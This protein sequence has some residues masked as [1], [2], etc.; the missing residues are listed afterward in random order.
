MTDNF[1]INTPII[2]VNPN[3][4]SDIEAIALQL[5]TLTKSSDNAGIFEWMT[6]RGWTKVCDWDYT[7][8]IGWKEL[9]DLMR[10]IFRNCKVQDT[11]DNPDI[12]ARIVVWE[13]DG[14]NPSYPIETVDLITPSGH[15]M[16]FPGSMN[17]QSVESLARGVAFDNAWIVSGCIRVNVNDAAKLET[18]KRSLVYN[19]VQRQIAL[20][21]GIKAWDDTETF[22]GYSIFQ[23]LTEME[24]VGIL[25]IVSQRSAPKSDKYVKKI[26][27]AKIP[28]SVKAS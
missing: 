13:T 24:S 25:R 26:W 6:K 9:R 23:A 18:V 17:F 15:L 14:T 11:C 21:K 22:Q 10:G 3:E 7:R 4:Q 28:Q 5:R 12:E 8:D 19:Y 27:T 20:C 16:H 2:Y 1:D